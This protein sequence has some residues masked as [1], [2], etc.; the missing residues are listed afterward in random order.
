MART[1]GS[2]GARGVVPDSSDQ[3]GLERMLL[4]HVESRRRD[5][6]CQQVE[7]DVVV[8][9]EDRHRH[10]G[11]HD[12]LAEHEGRQP[13]AETVVVMPRMPE[14]KALGAAEHFVRADG[15]GLAGNQPFL[16]G[17]GMPRVLSDGPGVQVDDPCPQ[18]GELRHRRWPV[19]VHADC[20]ERVVESEVLLV[21]LA[22]LSAIPLDAR[23]FP[24]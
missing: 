22:A 2:P 17:T 23:V 15:D 5:V 11:I 16:A 1:S 8:L 24:R 21:A 12:A 4:L 18:G 6:R 19:S 14:R 10:A 9:S 3:D 20:L 13:N 7:D